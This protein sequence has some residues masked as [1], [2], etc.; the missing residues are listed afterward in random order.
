M[1]KKKKVDFYSVIQNKKLPTLT[2]DARWHELFPDEKKTGR[3]KELEEKVNQLLK[4]QGKLVNDIEDMKKLKKSFME[5]IIVNM[6]AE[7]DAN[8]T[9][10]KR[11]DKNKRYINKLNDK[12]NEASDRLSRIPN[13]IKEANEELLI[14]SLRVCY[15]RIYSNKNE[16]AVIND[17]IRETREE[18]K[19]KILLKHDM[20]TYSKQIYSNLHDILGAEIINI[21]DGLQEQYEDGGENRQDFKKE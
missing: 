12:I 21:F 15:E 2:L 1:R 7:E 13:E 16:I 5:D 10:E 8:K 6:D 11:M 18:L 17:W 4:T 19:K 20:E 9:K 3:I 14:E